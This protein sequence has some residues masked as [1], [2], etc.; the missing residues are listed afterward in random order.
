MDAVFPVLAFGGYAACLVVAFGVRP[1]QR[2]RRTGRAGWRPPSSVMDLAAETLCT[3]GCLTT[4]AAPLL[5]LGGAVPAPDPTGA[6][7][8]VGLALLVAGT[9][10][11]L[12]AQRQM[13]DAWEPSADPGDGS[14]LVT[15]GMFGTVRTPF[16]LGC[17]LSSAAVAVV[18][19]N[20]VSVAGAVAVAVA[21]ELVVRFVEEPQLHAVH[22]PPYHEYLRRTGRFLPGIGR[23]D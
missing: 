19:P 6:R 4:A 2:R 14:Q 3:L 23:A 7:V 20:A 10:I 18:V 21:A 15:G 11:A 1:A 5:A 9:G 13:G 16:Y 17:M 12:V 8:G 22:G